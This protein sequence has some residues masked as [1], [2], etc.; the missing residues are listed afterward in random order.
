[1]VTKMSSLL[2]EF[3]NFKFEGVKAAYIAFPE[4]RE[5][6]TALFGSERVVV[7]VARVTP[8]LGEVYFTFLGGSPKDAILFTFEVSTRDLRRF[9]GFRCESIKITR[10]NFMF[11]G[12]IES[13]DKFV[14]YRHTQRSKINEDLDTQ[15]VVGHADQKST[16]APVCSPR[17]LHAPSLVNKASRPRGAFGREGH[18]QEPV[19][20]AG[21]LDTAK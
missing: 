2:T 8:K 3:G 11:R 7:S 12:T 9:Y 13:L 16:T 10:R 15:Y 5:Y 20:R 14:E 18:G 19:G 6:V 1:M 17:R 4:V 21:P